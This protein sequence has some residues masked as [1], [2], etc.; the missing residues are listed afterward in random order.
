MEIQE[1]SKTSRER[2]KKVNT[3]QSTKQEETK[4]VK[5]VK[6]AEEVKQ[7]EKI[8]E[9]KKLEVPKIMTAIAALTIRELVNIANEYGIKREDVITIVKD[10]G[11]YVL[12]HYSPS[13]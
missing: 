6:Y 2:I 5:E 1:K 7:V 10:N 12:I 11:Q 13:I 4:E 3:S 9:P 8:E